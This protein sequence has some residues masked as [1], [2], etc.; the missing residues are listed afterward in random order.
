MD[1]ES[2]LDGL[3]AVDIGDLDC[4]GVADTVGFDEDGDGVTDTA[5]SMDQS[6]GA[7]VVEH[8]ADDGSWVSL[9]HDP[10][11]AVVAA[12]FVD[13][14]GAV[15]ELTG[16]G[17]EGFLQDLGTLGAEDTDLTPDDGQPYPI[18]DDGSVTQVPMDPASCIPVED[19][20]STTEYQTWL[21]E[22]DL[23]PSTDGEEEL[24]GR[25]D[26]GVI[27]DVSDAGFWF[28]QSTDFTCAPSAATQIIEDF[29]DV[30]TP[31]ETEVA[32]W[33]AENG[34]LSEDG[35]APDALA[36]VLTEFGVPSSVQYN[37]DWDD[38]A[39]YLAE[40]RSVVMMVDSGD[41]W[42]IDDGEVE[43]SDADGVDHA[44]RVVAIDTNRGVV[45]LS[46]SGTPDGQQLEVPIEAM[47]EAWDD[48]TGTDERGEPMRER[49][50]VVSEESDQSENSAS[51]PQPAPSDGPVDVQLDGPADDPDPLAPIRHLTDPE[52]VPDSS[53]LISASGNLDLGSE[54]SGWFSNPAGWVIVPV[55]FAA[56]RV[57]SA[58]RKS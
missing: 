7:Y 3:E 1:I 28:E 15:T 25:T 6:T 57:F 47:E 48:V 11:G 18:Q 33:A 4:D 54:G 45:V 29:V 32:T 41:Y 43:D 58:L 22:S 34:I 31:D 44:V 23:T 17:I 5:V 24:D 56:S 49:L 55:V 13:P 2:Q 51:G 39:G 20:L 36:T 21:A 53:D 26:D 46:D 40:G 38:L 37:Q 30:D 27:G 12:T 19:V 8:A 50:L 14:V 9:T 10:S 52:D 16:D 42:G 35:M